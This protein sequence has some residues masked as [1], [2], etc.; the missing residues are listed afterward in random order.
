[1]EIEYLTEEPEIDDPSFVFFSRI[2]EAF[3]LTDTVR[4]D[5][6]KELEWAEQAESAGVHRKNGTKDGTRGTDGGSS[7]DKQE[8]KQE[9]PQLSKKSCDA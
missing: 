9:A 2:F 6:E 1:M 4:K 3:R 5:K 7:E 8:K